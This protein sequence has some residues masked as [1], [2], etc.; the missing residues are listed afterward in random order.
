MPAGR[1]DVGHLTADAT[2]STTTRDSVPSLPRS[3]ALL[4]SQQHSCLLWH[5]DVK[6]YIYEALRTNTNK[7]LD[8][9]THPLRLIELRRS[10][11][12]RVVL[13]RL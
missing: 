5:T 6:G 11:R 3:P 7:P 12:P 8:V 9:R 2:Q 10:N 4:V 13:G 1:I